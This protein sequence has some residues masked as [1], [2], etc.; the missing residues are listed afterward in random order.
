MWTRRT[1][2]AC[3]CSSVP[4]ARRAMKIKIRTSGF[5]LFLPVP[6]SLAGWAV[7]LVPNQAYAELGA[8]VPAPYAALV[9]REAVQVL[10]RECLDIFRD[11]KG[12]EIVHVEAQDGTFVSIRL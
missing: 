10:L 1:A 9:N 6:L 3:A 7:N 11:N 5:R 2:Q 8:H 12:L 4:D